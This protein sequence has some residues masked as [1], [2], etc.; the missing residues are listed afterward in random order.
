MK[1][2]RKKLASKSI[3]LLEKQWNWVLLILIVALRE[4]SHDR[5]CNYS[6]GV[7]HCVGMLATHYWQRQGRVQMEKDELEKATASCFQEPMSTFKLL[8]KKFF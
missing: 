5:D 1:Y 4:N 6:P 2:W 7:S 8:T 3:A